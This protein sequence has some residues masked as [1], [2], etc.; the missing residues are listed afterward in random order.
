MGKTRVVR[1]Q[2]LIFKSVLLKKH[3]N[4]LIGKG[5]INMGRKRGDQMACGEP[6]KGTS[7]ADLPSEV[8]GVGG[9]E[10]KR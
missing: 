6:Q 7:S 4:V 2:G 10:E 1:Q 3:N 9:D 5:E 8:K